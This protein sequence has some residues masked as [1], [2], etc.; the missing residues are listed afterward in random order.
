L[1]KLNNILLVSKKNLSF[2]KN[3]LGDFTLNKKFIRKNG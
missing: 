1:K 3:L 2:D